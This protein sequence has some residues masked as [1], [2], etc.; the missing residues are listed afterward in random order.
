MAPVPPPAPE[1]PSLPPEVVRRSLRNSIKDAVAWSVMQG[2]G[3]NY[4]T[5]FIVLGGKGLL[6]VGILAGL[7]ALAGGV[8]QW[9]AANV[10]DHVGRRS[11]IIVGSATFQALTWLP[12]CLAIFL[13][14]NVGYWIML[15]SFVLFTALANFGGPA[16]Q[17]LMGDL[18]PVERRGRYF[19]LRN[20]IS[21]G[22]LV[23][24]FL[25]GGAWLTF[26]TD[27]QAL[28]LLGLGG[29]D[30]GFLALFALAGAARLVSAWYLRRM[31]EP[32]YQHKPADRFTLLEFIRRAPRA[33]FGR[34]VFYC[35]LM[36]AGFGLVTP[37]LAWHMLDQLGFSP[38]VFAA[39]FACSQAAGVVSHAFSGWLVDRFG[40]KFVLALAG[41]TAVFVPL[42]LLPCQSFW[43][44][45]LV[46]AADGLTQA[47]FLF[48]IGN[49]L[50]DV[51]TPPKRTRC[52]AYHTLF[53]SLGTMAGG[54]LGA[55]LGTAVPLPLDVGGLT[56]GHPFTVLLLA[57]CLLRLVA[58]ILLL[59]TFE[60]FRLRRPTF[61]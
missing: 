38:A 25:A 2:L 32:A 21:G 33:H 10:T 37:F 61:A 17:S 16:W 15:A 19:G 44:F 29:R 47:V 27:N 18:V 20:A 46:M 12:I 9:A 34:F 56:L 49:Y 60:E 41:Q 14:L 57:S 35:A 26:C 53:V 51:V 45:V 55:L 43:H 28:A 13:P 23:A 8:V 7:P 50:Y 40:S 3:T 22:A 31:Y 6:Y 30:F 24:S 36:Y 59:G 11:T 39:A 48:A 4:V 52:V 42:L 5:P 54:L 58:N 1:A